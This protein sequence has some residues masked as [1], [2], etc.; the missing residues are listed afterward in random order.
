MA[1]QLKKEPF[2]ETEAVMT[3][4]ETIAVRQRSSRVRDIAFAV[5][6]VVAGAIS[7]STVSYAAH[8][9]QSNDVAKR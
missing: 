9:A 4:L 5:L 1:S 8:A 7:L 2:A 6:V 3:K